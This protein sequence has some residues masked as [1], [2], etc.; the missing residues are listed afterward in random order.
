MFIPFDVCLEL[1]S[2]PLLS[3]PSM[4]TLCFFSF[5]FSVESFLISSLVPLHS[6]SK[7]QKHWNII[8]ESVHHSH[9][10][11]LSCL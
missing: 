8:S 7:C 2:S 6:S 10:I 5:I 3:I 9:Y 11:S 1:S 4:E